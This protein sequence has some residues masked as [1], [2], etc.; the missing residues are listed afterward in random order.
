MFTI[1]RSLAKNKIIILAL[2][3]AGYFVFAGNKEAPK[4]KNAWDT[5]SVTQ[6]GAVAAHEASL[7]TK[8]LKALNSAAQYIGLE[9]YMPAALQEKAVG[10]FN[11]AGTALDNV[12]KQQD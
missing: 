2:L 1:A 5:V 10:G 9:E 3:L 12:G 6:P 8:A 11:T 4:P 7:T